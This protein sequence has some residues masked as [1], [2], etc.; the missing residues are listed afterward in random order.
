MRDHHKVEATVDNPLLHI[1]SVANGLAQASGYRVGFQPTLGVQFEDSLKRLMVNRQQA[2][3]L[4]AHVMR[5]TGRKPE[6]V[7]VTA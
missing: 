7:A 4:Y 6:D 1:V 2:A 3:I 5:I